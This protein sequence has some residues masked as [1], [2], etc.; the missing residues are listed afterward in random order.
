M[1]S[2]AATVFGFQYKINNLL[3]ILMAQILLLVFLLFHGH[4]VRKD[5]RPLNKHNLYPVTPLY[6]I[7]DESDVNISFM[8]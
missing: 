8:Q 7:W 4:H 2:Q 5:N 1:N 6:T 3:R